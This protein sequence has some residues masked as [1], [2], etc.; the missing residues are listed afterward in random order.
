[1][2]CRAA[3]KNFTDPLGALD[4][5]YRVLAPGG[6]AS[7]IDLRKECSP[8]EIEVEVESMALSPLNALWTRATFRRFPVLGG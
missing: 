1:V 7:I 3:F 2:I 8:A 5:I 6:Q 4:E